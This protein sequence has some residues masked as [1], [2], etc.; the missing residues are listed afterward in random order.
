MY[1]VLYTYIFVGIWLFRQVY[2]FLNIHAAYLT[3]PDSATL[4]LLFFSAGLGWAVRFTLASNCPHPHGS[5]GSCQW[6]WDCRGSWHWRDQG[7]AEGMLRLR[8]PGAAKGTATLKGKWWQQHAG[9]VGER[10][11]EK[12]AGL[13]GF[14]GS[15][16]DCEQWG[17]WGSCGGWWS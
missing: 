4:P 11:C 13:R 5:S 3:F 14:G 1:I 12:A 8:G 6:H 15:E 9:T 16:G 17:D 7:A 2:V 10:G